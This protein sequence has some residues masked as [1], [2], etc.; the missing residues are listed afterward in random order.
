MRKLIPLLVI[1]GI[2]TAAVVVTR[3]R[4]AALDPALM[5]TPIGGTDD[6]PVPPGV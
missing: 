6:M 4:R 2:A 1:A 3:R 5:S